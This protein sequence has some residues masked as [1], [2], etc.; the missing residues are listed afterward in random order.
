MHPGPYPSSLQH[1]QQTVPRD[2]IAA[3]NL[4]QRSRKLFISKPNFA[5]SFKIAEIKYCNYYCDKRIIM[6]ALLCSY[7]YDKCLSTE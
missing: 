3:V 7:Y 2:N 6:I 4:L 5:R 1:T